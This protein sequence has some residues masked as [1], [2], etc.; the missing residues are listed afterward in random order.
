M[1]GKGCANSGALYSDP[2]DLEA[3]RGPEKK[4]SD[5]SPD[6]KPK[7][8]LRA[9][10]RQQ[11]Q[12]RTV[13]V[14]KLV[15]T[16]HPVR[17]IWEFVGRLDLSKFLQG[18][19]AVEGVAGRAALD[20][21]L[22]I[23][24]W[25]FAYSE[26]V[27]SA[28]E[29]S[30]LCEY[31]PAFQWLTGMEEINHHTLSSFRVGHREDLD[32]LFADVLGVMSAEG[33]ITMQRVMHDGTKVK[34]NAGVDTYRK[35]E[36][37]RAHLEL[38]QQQIKEL[39][40]PQTEEVSQRVAKARERAV[41][42]RAERLEH[43]LEELDK[44]R[45]NKTGTKAKEEARVSETDPEARMMK[46][47]NGGFAPSYNVQ[48]STDAA[49]GVIVGVEVT[50][51]GSDYGELVPAVESIQE[52]MGQVPAQIVVDGG[53]VSRENVLAMAEKQVDLIGPI[54]TGSAQSAGQMD[55]RGVD[56]AFRPDAFQYCSEADTVTC[57]GGKTLA[58]ESTEARPGV[59]FHTY[60]A[61]HTDCEACPFRQKCCPQ[62]AAKGRSIVRSINSSTVAAFIDKMQTEKARQIYKQRGQVAEFPN[63]WIKEK[64]GLRQFRLRGRIKA[65]IESTWACLTY[66][67]QQWIR[68]RW[69]SEVSEA[70]T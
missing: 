61:R 55:R 6:L 28:R 46:Q 44:V 62:N 1:S 21:R 29:V 51:S 45:A 12:M 18:I 65:W 59:L 67:I 32:Q 53:F 15:E 60:R 24:L 31:H 7:P 22:L 36:K 52:N 30:R 25:V 63:A 58:H 4:D 2:A 14:E 10:D 66:N 68:L 20:P 16:D 19:E 17:A 70:T 5:E 13:E 43:A 34:A 56:P 47:S 9:V 69:R 54:P 42:E 41:R 49:N 64:I 48:I 50:Q 23:S 8:R 26:G 11:L 57:P 40:D 39:G 37:I 38:A 27:S 35:E 33:L 3:L